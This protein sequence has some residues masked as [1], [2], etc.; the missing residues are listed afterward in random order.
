MAKERLLQKILSVIQR[1][2]KI[3]FARFMELALYD[4]DEGYYSGDSNIGFQ[5]DY[6]TSPHLHPLFGR[7]VAKQLVEMI[8]SLGG[9]PFSL[10]EFGGGKGLLAHDILFY[11]EQ[12]NNGLLDR[13][14][15]ILVERSERMRRVQKER[16]EPW[17]EKVTWYEELAGLPLVETGCFFSNELFDAFPVHRLLLTGDRVEEIHVTVS[18]ETW[19]EVLAS[20]SSDLLR[21]LIDR[22]DFK[23]QRPTQI[24]VNLQARQWIGEMAKRI[25]RGFILTIDYG[26]LAHDLY[27]ERR[28]RGSLLCYYRH[29]VNEEPYK[30]IGEQ[31]ITSHVNFT[32][33]IQAGEEAGLKTV[34]FTDQTNFLLGLGMAEAMEPIANQREES[35]EREREFLALKELLNPLGMGRVFKVLVQSK[36]VT[37]ERLSGM[38]FKPFFTKSIGIGGSAHNKD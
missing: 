28:P 29:T 24:E 12:E 32:D 22:L 4:P 1:E 26:Y 36:G 15:Y 7:L 18:G 19:G 6:F 21:S 14:R 2:G 23:P 13:L 8:H 33:L 10:V 34:G 5:G 35:P 20:P 31:D 27:T 16:L 25:S 9:G 37:N 11:I 17:K 30:R 38:T 3:P